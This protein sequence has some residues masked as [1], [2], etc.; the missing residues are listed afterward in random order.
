MPVKA[1][2]FNMETILKQFH[3]YTNGSST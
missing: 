2:D 1:A 3:T